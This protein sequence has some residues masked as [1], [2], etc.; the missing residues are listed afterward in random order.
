VNTDGAV[1]R[2]EDAWLSFPMLK[3]EPRG[4]K[5]AFLAHAL[6]RL[7]P[8]SERTFWALQ[9]VS[10]A[11]RRGEVVG[12]VG[13]NGSGKSTLLRVVAGIYA[14]DR[15]RA[16]TVGRIS[17]L[18]ELGAGFRDELSGHENVRLAGAIMGLSARETDRLTASIVEFAELDG[19]MDQPLRTYSSGMRARLGFS[20]AVA[21]DPD[22][23]LVDEVLAVGDAR[24][25]AKSMARM[26]EMVRSERTTVVIVSHDSG[27]LTR[28]AHRLVLLDR[29]QVVD[30][31]DPATVLARYTALL[32]VPGAPR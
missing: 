29:G 6:R 13:R 7:K 14:P 15:G 23:L 25:R 12:L 20:V 31:G 26:R 18:L 9:G 16:A 1:I 19:F 8:A 3:H 4:L 27:E 5:E 24:F 32:E 10:L 2:V 28:L 11:V 17:S 21:A 22:I 30:D